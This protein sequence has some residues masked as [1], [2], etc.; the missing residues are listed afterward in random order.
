[1]G[2][3]IREAAAE[4]MH[5]KELIPGPPTYK[6]TLDASGEGVGRVWVP[7][8][9]SLA[10]IVWRLHWPDEVVRRL[11]TFD[12]PDGDITNSD[13]EMAAEVLGWLVLEA[14][15]PKRHAHVGVCSDN[16]ATVY[17][18]LKGASKRSAV[19]NR[20]LRVLAVQMRENRASLLITRHIAG[21]CNDLGDIPSRSFGYKA[22]WYF[23]E[24]SEFLAFFNKRFSMPQKN[25]WTG[26]RL[27][28]AVSS[29]VICELL[30]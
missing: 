19:A 22:E 30:T 2:Q 24:D 4:P 26:F 9:K 28:S 21:E 25:S 12:N 13:L 23:E 18:Q 20:I 15:A 11:V 3:L 1:M 16:L 5:V 17:W 8:E 29:R 7:G 10:P 27:S 14:N 6:G